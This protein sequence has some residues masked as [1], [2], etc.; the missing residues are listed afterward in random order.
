MPGRKA[1][2]KAVAGCCISRWKCGK[3]FFLRFLGRNV[4]QTKKVW[5]ATPKMGDEIF[6]M[7]L[8]KLCFALISYCALCHASAEGATVYHLIDLGSLPGAAYSDGRA[9]NSSGQ[10]TGSTANFY[11]G[12]Y[13]FTSGGMQEILPLIGDSTIQGL[14]INSGGQV[15]GQSYG[16][17]TN[18]AHAFVWSSGTGIQH[19]GNSGFAM[20]INDNG[21]A[22][23][24]EGNSF[25]G[26]AFVWTSEGGM[27]LIGSLPGDTTA[28]GTAINNQGV[29]TGFSYGSG[30][31]GFLWSATDG[32]SQIPVPA[33]TSLLSPRDLNDSSRVVGAIRGESGTHAFI[34]S[35]ETGLATLGVLPGMDASYAVGINNFGAVVG[36]SYNA[37]GGK[38]V[39]WT[40][41]GGLIDLN[42]VVDSSGAGW[43]LSAAGGINDSGW[44]VGTGSGPHG[45][46][47]FILQP[48]EGDL[49]HKV[50][51]S[52]G[53]VCLFGFAIA[54]LCGVRCYL[55]RS[56][57]V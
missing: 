12:A 28:Y 55:N 36:G 16:N 41:S 32:M 18:S 9:I 5:L 47:A 52:G 50:P 15:V 53:A 1:S 11:G 38:A 25:G 21:Q 42:D 26:S 48:Y 43:I 2:G 57:G 22:V 29:V 56:I 20:D 27:Q 4:L 45:A 17:S 13:F 46:H 49:P 34:W 31:H 7:R 35:A 3:P 6:R 14:G 30:S 51:E 37:N 19:I 33:G 40:E 54:S 44:I 23:G 39:L 10:A 8:G 24:Y